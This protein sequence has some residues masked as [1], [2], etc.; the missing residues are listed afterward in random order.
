MY[1]AFLMMFLVDVLV[2]GAHLVD[3]MVR[4]SV[5]RVFVSPIGR[6]VLD[7]VQ[8][9]ESCVVICVL[10]CVILESFVHLMYYVD[11]M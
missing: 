2:G 6:H 3:I 4:R 10:H 9:L 11:N 8:L 7:L 5:I 1:L